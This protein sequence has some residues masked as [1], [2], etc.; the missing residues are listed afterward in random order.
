MQIFREIVPTTEYSSVALGFFDG[1]HQGHKAVI[2]KAVNAEKDG[3]VPAVYTFFESPRGILS[4]KAPEMLETRQHKEKTLD[5]LGIKRL[6][7][8]DFN[9]VKELSPRAFVEKVLSGM[10]NAKKVFCG[11]NY[12]FGKGGSG[13]GETLVSLCRELDIQAEVIPPV[14]IDGEVASSTRIRSLLQKGNIKQANRLL[15]YDFG[16][17]TEIIH[18]NHIGKGLGFPTINQQAEPGIILPKFGVYASVVTVDGKRYCG[19]TNVGIK[20]TIGNYNP[21]YETWMP[22][23]KGNDIYGKTVTVKLKEFIRPE[24][25]F[26]NIEQL[27]KTVVSNGQQAL[28]IIGEICN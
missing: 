11:F 20:P 21:L 8:A 13:N 18:G 5:K 12:H 2:E 4:G 15:G 22:L 25:K 23:Y 24:R 26:E 3:L 1:I 14:I 10:L 28:E 17:K 6:Y 9:S 7:Y 19:V 16:L 27:K